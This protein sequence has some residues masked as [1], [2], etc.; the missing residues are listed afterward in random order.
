M[1]ETAVAKQSRGKI[2]DQQQL[3]TFFQQ[4]PTSK[5]MF[6][7]DMLLEPRTWKELTASDHKEEWLQACKRE[8]RFLQKIGTFQ[9]MPP[10]PA[11][12][13]LAIGLTWVWK[14]K[15]DQSGYVTKFKARLC[16]RGDQQLP[17][18]QETYAATLAARTFRTLM[19]ICA[20]FD[21]DTYQLDAVNAFTN[22][23]LDEEVYVRAPAGWSAVTG[24][25]PTPQGQPHIFRLRRALYGLRR[26][27]LLWLQLLSD[28]MKTA[29]LT[30]ITEDPCVFIAPEDSPLRGIIVF[31]YV[32]DII[33]MSLKQQAQAAASLIQLLQQQFSLHVLGPVKWFLGIRIT[34]DRPNRKI[35]LT[36]DNYIEEKVKSLCI[37]PTSRTYLTPL[38]AD[39]APTPEDF[40]A[41]HDS[42]HY[43]QRKVGSITYAATAGRPDVA[44][45]ASRLSEFLQNPTEE[46]HN[47]ANRCLLYLHQTKQ[48]SLVYGESD[49]QS[50]TL[51]CATDAAFA[52][53][54]STRRS[55]QGYTVTLF[56][57]PVDWK[58]S[59]QRS[60]VT[61]ST[62]AEL[63]ALGQG[64]RSF[65]AY[66]R[67]LQQLEL[68][69]KQ[70]KLTI[71]CD[72]QQTIGLVTKKNP[73]L[74]T[75]L[76]HVD[77]QRLWIR[78]AI[79][80]QQLLVEWVSTNDMISDGLTKVLPI[81]KFQHFIQLLRMEDR[82]SGE[83][84]PQ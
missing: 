58:A 55:S 9:Q 84:Q 48:R 8:V 52:D 78:Q 24:E 35:W 22:A 65:L 76:K 51:I 42:I 2:R 20:E 69:F 17:T 29:G 14:Y 34:R 4:L 36:L 13:K 71:S 79:Q 1:G 47:S 81:Q 10:D 82:P 57:G 45:A 31:F 33:I 15:T 25:D 53:D 3:S 23:P 50:P 74:T 30:P 32:D 18:Q 5:P 68:R 46:H 83:I 56:G 7:M 80:R 41:S 77:V 61:S 19:A 60:V 39:P 38:S 40:Q 54:P 16:V 43:Y 6:R 37:P 27:P 62:E 44:K 64:A 70:P 59:K 12:T 49:P 11:L 67:L 26:S 63:H 66:Q 21:M 75:S 72:N 73:Q 28:A